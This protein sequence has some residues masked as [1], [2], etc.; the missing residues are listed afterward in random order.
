MTKTLRIHGYH[1]DAEQFGDLG[2]YGSDAPAIWELM[3]SEPDMAFRLHESLP[4]C[5]AQVV[6]AVRHEMARTLDDV[7]SRRTR[8]LPLNARAA[9]EMAP[10]VA[11]LMAAELGKDAGWEAAEVKAFRAVAAGYFVKQHSPVG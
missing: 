2:Y 3:E 4:I 1:E 7:L 8:A 6:W 9:V 11:R 10:A 5:G